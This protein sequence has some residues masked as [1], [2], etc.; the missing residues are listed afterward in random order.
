MANP[1][2]GFKERVA[3]NAGGRGSPTLSTGNDDDGTPGMPSP[4]DLAM[5]FAALL[6]TMGV[7]TSERAELMK[8]TDARKWTLIQKDGTRRVLLPV[9]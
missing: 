6:D 1:S 8:L 9:E 7:S 2:F 5:Q 3:P 4:S